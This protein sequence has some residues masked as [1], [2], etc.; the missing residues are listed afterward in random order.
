LTT[1]GSTS[2]RER[3]IQAHDIRALA[4]QAALHFASATGIFLT[5]LK[6]ER[7]REK[8]A[9]IASALSGRV[10]AITEALTSAETSTRG[11]AR[12]LI[13]DLNDLRDILSQ[14]RDYINRNARR[15]APREGDLS[16][17]VAQIEST[18]TSIDEM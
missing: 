11:L 14:W 9:D 4:L 15:V 16:R 18:L 7:G 17:L 6:L 12:Q 8:F 3:D 10:V 1:R 13:D 2:T 5:C